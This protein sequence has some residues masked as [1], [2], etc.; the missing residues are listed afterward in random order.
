MSG[1]PQRIH[2]GSVQASPASTV[3]PLRRCLQQAY[4]VVTRRKLQTS[5][6]P[7]EQKRQGTPVINPN[8]RHPAQLRDQAPG[9]IERAA[10]ETR[11]TPPTSTA[12]MHASI[13]ATTR[14]HYPHLTGCSPEL[15][16]SYM[17]MASKLFT[18]TFTGSSPDTLSQRSPLRSTGK[19]SC[20][21]TQTP[22]ASAGTRNAPRLGG[23]CAGVA[24]GQPRARGQPV[25]GGG[26]KEEGAGGM[27]EEL[28][29]RGI[30]WW[31]KSI[32]CCCAAVASLTWRVGRR[33]QGDLSGA[34]ATDRHS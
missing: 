27:S 26:A 29:G 17:D 22:P 7:E 30:V 2:T 6:T 8:D 33:V 14:H 10:Q 24:D 34:G 5:G 25:G 28:A 3:L 1:H 19:L 15:S 18:F 32:L 11:P 12:V 4:G 31:G 21:T 9:T 16:K 13:T 23:Q 20:T